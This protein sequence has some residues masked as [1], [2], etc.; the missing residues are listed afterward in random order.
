[1][2]IEIIFAFENVFSKWIVIDIDVDFVFMFEPNIACQNVFHD[3]SDEQIL[4]LKY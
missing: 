1:M 3:Q 4:T 2:R